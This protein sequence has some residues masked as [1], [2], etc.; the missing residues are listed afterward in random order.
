[1]LPGEF[2]GP[3]QEQRDAEE[4]PAEDAR[5]SRVR[6]GIAEDALLVGAAQPEGQSGGERGQHAW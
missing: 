3:R 1:M 4:R 2:G 5:Q 6:Q